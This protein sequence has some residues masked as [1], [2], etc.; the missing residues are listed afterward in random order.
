MWVICCL[1]I[2]QQGCL[3]EIGKT[4]GKLGKQW[5]T[6]LWPGCFV[7]DKVY[8]TTSKEYSTVMPMSVKDDTGKAKGK[9]TE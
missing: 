5:I 3:S 4:A 6:N 8:K 1:H 9:A 2:G 7:Q